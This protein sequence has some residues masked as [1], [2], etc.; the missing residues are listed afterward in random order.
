MHSQIILVTDSHPCLNGGGISQTL[1]NILSGCKVPIFLAVNKNY[2]Q[3]D[4][5]DF[6]KVTLL[7]YEFFQLPY[8]R[9]RVGLLLN[10]Y[11]LKFNLSILQIS[12]IKLASSIELK[13]SVILVSTTDVYKLLLAFKIH[14]QTSIPIVSYFMDDWLATE[15]VTWL[16]NNAQKLGKSVLM[17]SVKMLF[18]SNTLQTTLF[19]RYS[20]QSKPSL[21]IHNPVDVIDYSELFLHKNNEKDCVKI[22]YA[23]SIWPMHLDAIVLLAENLKYIVDKF[24]VKLKL[25]IYAPE[26]HW[27]EFSDRLNKEYVFYNGF[28]KYSELEQILISADI[29]LVTASFTNEYHYY[30]SSSVQTKIT[31][32]MRVGKPI[33]SIAPKSSAINEFIRK[34]N[35]GVVID[36]NSNV[37][38]IDA[39]I[40]ALCHLQKYGDK[41]GYNGWM[42]AKTIFSKTFVRKQFAQFMGIN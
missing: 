22:V 8:L 15:K 27:N 28:R 12:R 23:G 31:D 26:S 25:E 11:I 20:L 21:I 38:F 7:A 42:A 39:M 6:L 4:Y 3:L 32:Y 14:N 30:S 24:K 36:S 40:E 37:E 1:Y 17:A 9:N 29:L 13:N 41:L 16:N 10:P 5:K 2:K 19:D 35:C 34:W 18:I 33:L